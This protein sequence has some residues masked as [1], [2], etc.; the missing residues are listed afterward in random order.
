[1]S[2]IEQKRQALFGAYPGEKWAEKVKQMSE[3]QVIAVYMN[4]KRQNKV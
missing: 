4:L 1:V 2:E 3:A